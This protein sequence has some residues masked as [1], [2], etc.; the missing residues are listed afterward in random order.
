MTKEKLIKWLPYCTLSSTFVWSSSVSLSLPHLYQLKLENIFHED[1][2]KWELLWNM[3]GPHIVHTD[4]WAIPQN[5][6][7]SK[8]SSINTNNNNKRY[9]S[10]LLV[11]LY[12]F[13]WGTQC[14]V[15]RL[16]KQPCVR[17]HVVRNL[18]QLLIASINQPATWITHL[19]GGSSSPSEAFRWLQSWLTSW[20]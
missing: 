18:L 3:C 2:Q 10:F 9:C 12:Y 11:L 7:F 14:H 20:L 19:G 1:P 8:K 15:M 13:L 16:L 5:R 17:V 6:L 4:Q